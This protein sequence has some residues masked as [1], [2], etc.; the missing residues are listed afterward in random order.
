MGSENNE[1]QK[2]LAK[3]DELHEIIKKKDKELEEM[4]QNIPAKEKE[5][6]LTQMIVWVIQK[7]Q[8]I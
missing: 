7:K 5:N 3:I 4:K 8:L 2:C 1:V 6:E